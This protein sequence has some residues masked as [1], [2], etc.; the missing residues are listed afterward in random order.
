MGPAS[1][2]EQWRLRTVISN[3]RQKSLVPEAGQKEVYSSG[4]WVSRDHLA[5][6]HSM[7]QTNAPAQL[8][9]LHSAALGLGQ[10]GIG[11]RL[12]HGLQLS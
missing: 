12:D 2:S 3:E 10:P 8:S 11:K 1:P 6:C 4:Y 5:V 9:P 7:G